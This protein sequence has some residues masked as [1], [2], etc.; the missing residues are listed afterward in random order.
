[1]VGDGVH[2]CYHGFVRL[3]ELLGG[4]R[5]EV[6][7]FDRSSAAARWF[8]SDFAFAACVGTV[9]EHHEVGNAVALGV[10]YGHN[11][12]G[13]M[14][15]KAGARAQPQLA[16]GRSACRCPLNQPIE[17]TGISARS[18]DNAQRPANH[19]GVGEA[20][21]RCEGVVDHLHNARLLRRNQSL[22]ARRLFHRLVDGSG[23]RAF[24]LK[25]AAMLLSC[26]AQERRAADHD[27]PGLSMSTVKYNVNGGCFAG[28]RAPDGG[29]DL[30][31]I[32]ERAHT[33]VEASAYHFI[34][35]E[36]QEVMESG[37]GHDDLVGRGQSYHDLDHFHLTG[38]C[39]VV[40]KQVFA[41]FCDT[42]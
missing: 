32:G 25:Q 35:A 34:S 5:F 31:G 3:P 41:L 22:P 30:R 7:L 36:L 17:L 15:L 40:F 39:V 9:E 18:L 23:L 33:D 24:Q 10:D 13:R 14:K 2:R 8:D 4:E 11:R 27:I 19:L 42:H 26:M 28:T 6:G 20:E 38:E 16:A 1:M 29:I 37:V 12:D 21:H